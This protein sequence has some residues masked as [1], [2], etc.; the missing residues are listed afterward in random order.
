MV[1]AKCSKY[2]PDKVPINLFRFEEDNIRSSLHL[3]CKDC[4]YYLAVRRNR[5]IQKKKEKAIANGKFYCIK[6]YLIKELNERGVNLDGSFSTICIPCKE[7][8]LIKS[9]EIQK[10]YREI[11]F[12]FMLE[13]NSCCRNC[14]RI[15]LVVDSKIIRLETE[16]VENKRMVTYNE[17]VYEASEFIT[18]YRDF[19]ELS[20]MDLDHM[21]EA[22]L[23]NRGLLKEDEKFVPKKKEISRI[24]G[25]K[26]MELEARKCQLLCCECHCIL[27]EKRKI[28]KRGSKENPPKSA[29]EIEKGKYVNSLKANGCSSCGYVG[30]YHFMEMNHVNPSEKEERISVMVHSHYFTLDQVKEEC[31][32]TEVLCRFCHRLHTRKQREEGIISYGRKNKKKGSG[33][34]TLSSD[35][36][37][38]ELQVSDSEDEVE[39][40]FQENEEELQLFDS[41]DELENE[42]LEE[43]SP[44]DIEETKENG[45]SVK[46]ELFLDIGET[47]EEESP[48][49]EE[50]ESLVENEPQREVIKRSAPKLKILK[51]EPPQKPQQNKIKFVRRHR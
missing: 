43:E 23:R 48:P 6:C 7:I 1:H 47:K 51:R 38:K 4:R 50:H 33:D 13:I 42:E 35:G 17:L 21:S 29:Y 45:E 49:L 18:K 22:D 2:P 31:K 19:I 15:F 30:Y 12:N 34:L 28:E 25:P 36:E 37:E 9:K 3:N 40:F 14:N 20:F 46:E 24:A 5:L 27:T 8:S 41:E 10:K 26:A 39:D 11:K 32:K 16:V 44:S